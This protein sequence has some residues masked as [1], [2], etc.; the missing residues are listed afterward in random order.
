MVV[1]EIP[2]GVV[3]DHRGRRLSY[4]LGT[5]ALAASTFG[6]YLL[7]VAHA[8]FAWW[9]IVSMLLGLGYTFFSGAT[10]AWLVDALAF[11]GLGGV[12]TDPAELPQRHDLLVA[13][14][15]RVELRL[16]DEQH[17][18]YRRPAGAGAGGR[19]VSYGTSFAI[20]AVVQL[21]AIPLLLAGRARGHAADRVSPPTA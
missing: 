1:F 15:D 13:T 16:D 4:L 11:A 19:R 18:R 6:Y 3:A 7:W 17:R 20:G 21:A 10:D 2:T 5:L 8:P 14:G 12:R 9:A